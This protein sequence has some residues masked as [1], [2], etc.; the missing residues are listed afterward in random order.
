MEAYRF[1]ER[2]RS[3][4]PVSVSAPTDTGDDMVM[5]GPRFRSTGLRGDGVAYGRI[6]VVIS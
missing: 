6:K 1:G 2:V 3:D 5:F 4:G